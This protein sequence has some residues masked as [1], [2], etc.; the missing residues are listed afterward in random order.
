MAHRL[1]LLLSPIAGRSY[2]DVA[3]SYRRRAHTLE[4]QLRAERHAR[5]LAE[6]RLAQA[7]TGEQPAADDLLQGGWATPALSTQRIPDRLLPLAQVLPQQ[8]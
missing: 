7:L 3:A 6:L 2:R 8:E 4:V 1:P 5:A